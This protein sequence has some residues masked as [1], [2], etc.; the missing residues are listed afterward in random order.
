MNKKYRVS[1]DHMLS[2]LL[3]APSFLM[4]H[5][6]ALETEAQRTQR[7][8]LN[9]CGGGFTDESCLIRALKDA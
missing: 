4:S 8:E 3:E 5:L 9:S 1:K 2:T 7:P 6:T